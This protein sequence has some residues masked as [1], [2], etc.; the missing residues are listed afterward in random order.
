MSRARKSVWLALGALVLAL[1]PFPLVSRLEEQDGF[2]RSCHMPSEE[3]YYHRAQSALVEGGLAADLSSAH[4]AAE[5]SFRCI[6]CHRGDDSLPDRLRTLQLAGRDALRW[7]SGQADPAVEKGTAGDL[8]LLD[9]GCV[10]CHA[11]TLLAPGFENHFHHQLPQAKAAAASAQSPVPSW[12]Q[13]AA[14]MFT[15]LGASPT[16]LLCQDCHQAH[17]ELPAGESTRFLD[18]EAVLLPACVQC[19]EETGKGPL[20]LARREAGFVM[21]PARPPAWP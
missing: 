13:G 12:E 8:L 19:H 15:A 21:Q 3:T 18:V 6:D 11:E 2:C 14:Q 9:R 20:D 16:T 10:R 7:L 17:I 4:Y 1:V 5:P